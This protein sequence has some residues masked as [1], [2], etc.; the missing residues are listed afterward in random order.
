MDTAVDSGSL[1]V[2]GVNP[3]EFPPDL[4][5]LNTWTYRFDYDEGDDRH[6]KDEKG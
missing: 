1:C 2:L 3:M 6:G 5:I 4:L